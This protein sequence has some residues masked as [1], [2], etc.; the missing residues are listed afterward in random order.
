MSQNEDKRNQNRKLGW[1]KIIGCIHVGNQH[2]LLFPHLED[3]IHDACQGP[4]VWIA[5]HIEDVK[6]PFVQVFQL[7]SSK[8]EKFGN[9]DSPIRT[10]HYYYLFGGQCLAKSWVAIESLLVAW[11]FE[12]GKVWDDGCPPHVSYTFLYIFSEKLGCVYL[13]IWLLTCN[14]CVCAIYPSLTNVAF[15]SRCKWLEIILAHFP[16]FPPPRSPAHEQQLENNLRE[17]PLPFGDHH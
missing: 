5:S 2:L 11:K 8:R 1:K 4:V 9:K 7:L 13:Y 3:G 17:T 12:N 14:C 6:A 16:V 10:P 15:S